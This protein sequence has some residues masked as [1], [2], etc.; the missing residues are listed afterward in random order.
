MSNAPKA[1]GPGECRPASHCCSFS[2]PTRWQRDSAGYDSQRRRH[3][4]A[5]QPACRPD[6]AVTPTG[7]QRDTACPARRL[8]QVRPDLAGVAGQR[9][10]LRCVLSS[11]CCH[12][13]TN[14]PSADVHP[15]KCANT[16][17]LYVAKI[18]TPKTWADCE[19]NGP[20]GIRTRGWRQIGLESTCDH[21]V[22]CGNLCETF[23]S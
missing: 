19:P 14:A 3:R 23:R 1:F 17:G 15:K 10:P 5:L 18:E 6:A 8:K 11:V 13:S 9:R 20:L 7:V 12:G 21:Q 22:G 2:L 16:P 4:R